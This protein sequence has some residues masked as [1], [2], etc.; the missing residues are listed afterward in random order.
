MA[1]VRGNLEALQEALSKYFAPKPAA[2]KSA[3]EMS[4]VV[5]YVNVAASGVYSAPSQIQ[6]KGY[7]LRLMREGSS[8]GVACRVSFS[9]VTPSAHQGTMLRPGESVRVERGFN[10]FWVLSLAE[11]EMPSTS[12]EVST[13]RFAIVRDP[14]V[15]FNEGRRSSSSYFVT[16]ESPN[17]G[18]PIRGA[19]T[20]AIHV[21]D[22]AT[23]RLQASCD[24]IEVWWKMPSG[25]WARNPADD[26]S[27]AGLGVASDI[28]DIEVY[29]VPMGATHVTLVSVSQYGAYIVASGGPHHA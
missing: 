16:E 10:A 25:L 13:L 7:E 23:G 8:P 21:V 2:H 6:G 18:M 4:E 5:G 24:D 27:A 11:N 1:T 22:S 3:T 29:D 12:G 14:F 26:F 17:D 15:T 19:A 9:G 28:H 20:V